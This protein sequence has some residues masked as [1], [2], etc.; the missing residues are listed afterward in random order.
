MHRLRPGLPLLV[1]SCI[2]MSVSRLKHPF[3]GVHR[4][5]PPRPETR[6]GSMNIQW[7]G[8]TAILTCRG[9]NRGSGRPNLIIGDSVEYL[10]SRYP[11]RIKLVNVLPG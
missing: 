3:V 2:Q 8:A 5:R 1:Q 10:L 7:D 9:I 4:L 6:R 11:R